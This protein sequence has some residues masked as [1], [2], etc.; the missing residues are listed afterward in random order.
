M[1]F[2][3]S[4]YFHRWSRLS[5][6]LHFMARPKAIRPSPIMQQNATYLQSC[7][8]ISLLAKIAHQIHS[9]WVVSFG[10]RKDKLARRRVGP[11]SRSCG[12]LA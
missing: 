7:S 10:D 2:C 11:I 1:P 8:K 3:M 12:N 9:N 5:A 4:F 6:G